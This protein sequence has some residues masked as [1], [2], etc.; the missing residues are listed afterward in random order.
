[1]RYFVDTM[2]SVEMQGTTASYAVAAV[3]LPALAYPHILQCYN[4]I[5]SFSCVEPLYFI[6]GDERVACALK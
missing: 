6:K 4:T 3:T 5:P 2:R 1:M